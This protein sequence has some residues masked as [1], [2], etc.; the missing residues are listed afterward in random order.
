MII[1]TFSPGEVVPDYAG[2]ILNLRYGN[3]EIQGLFR[4]R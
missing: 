4:G 2:E 1:L 3:I